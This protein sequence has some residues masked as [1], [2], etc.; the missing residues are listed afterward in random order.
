M[1]SPAGHTPDSLFGVLRDIGREARIVARVGR[2]WFGPGGVFRSGTLAV[3]ID[4]NLGLEVLRSSSSPPTTVVTTEL[5]IDFTGRRAELGETIVVEGGMV[6]S[7]GVGALSSSRAFSEDGEILAVATSAMRFV[8]LGP[9]HV[10]M[11]RDPRQ[12]PAPARGFD[13]LLG[14]IPRRRGGAVIIETV[15]PEEFANARRTL[16]GGVSAALAEW[17]AAELLGPEGWGCQTL[18]ASY[19]RP[20]PTGARF[21]VRAEPRRI[22]RGFALVDVTVATGDEPAVLVRLGFRRGSASAHTSS[23]AASAVSSET[24]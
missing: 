20:I 1:T 23:R 7:D 11:A 19:L 2:P 16:Q 8:P 22:G 13:E 3:P 12:F 4:V 18:R 10:P 6:S 14:A 15:C 21:T 9:V 17:A 24:K 5:S